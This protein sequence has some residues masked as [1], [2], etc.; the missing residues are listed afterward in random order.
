MN[1]PTFKFYSCFLNICKSS[2]AFWV[3]RQLGII[4]LSFPCVFKLPSR[5][6]GKDSYECDRV[7]KPAFRWWEQSGRGKKKNEKKETLSCT[8]EMHPPRQSWMCCTPQPIRVPLP[9]HL[10]GVKPCTFFLI[11]WIIPG[12]GGGVCLPSTPLLWQLGFT[13]GS[14]WWG[15]VRGWRWYKTSS[16]VNSKILIAL[17]EQVT[18]TCAPPHFKPKSYVNRKVNNTF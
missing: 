15:L 11:I 1:D 3:W 17:K 7:C 5:S 16:K 6:P 14:S 12:G 8:L 13:Q 2:V 18:F 4:P 9:L 10:F